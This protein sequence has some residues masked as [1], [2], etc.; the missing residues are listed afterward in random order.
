MCAYRGLRRDCDPRSTMDSERH[1]VEGGLYHHHR[2]PSVLQGLVSPL[3]QEFATAWISSVMEM[4]ESSAFVPLPVQGIR[5]RAFT[6]AFSWLMRVTQVTHN[7]MFCPPRSAWRQ[8]RCSDSARRQWDC[9][10]VEEVE[11]DWVMMVVFFNL[12]RM[13]INLVFTKSYLRRLW[14][15]TR[16][17]R[18]WSKICRYAARRFMFKALAERESSKLGGKLEFARSYRRLQCKRCTYSWPF[19]SSAFPHWFWGAH[20]QLW[21]YYL[22]RLGKDPRILLPCKY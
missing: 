19:T 13:L 1:A 15:F 18:F 12:P 8:V 7:I 5:T 11:L 14:L 16:M 22:A 2:T 3:T 21:F 20:L 10:L 4:G 9:L 6:L 17:E